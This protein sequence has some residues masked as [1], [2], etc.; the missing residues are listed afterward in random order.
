MSA[1]VSPIAEAELQVTA[2]EIEGSRIF[3]AGRAEPGASLRGLADERA[4]GTTKA[5]ADGHFIIEGSIDLS[6]GDHMIAV[7]KLDDAGQAQVRVAVSFNR[8]PGEQVAA[9]AG[10]PDAVSPIDAGAFDRLQI[11]RAH[12]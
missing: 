11:G 12:V 10:A 8:P 6:V 3:V 2:G 1:P 4:I 7:E 5:A 9:V